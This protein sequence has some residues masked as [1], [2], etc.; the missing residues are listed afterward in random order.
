VAMSSAATS[1]EFAY[2]P[3]VEFIVFV[4]NEINVKE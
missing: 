3:D 1:G 4:C 2:R